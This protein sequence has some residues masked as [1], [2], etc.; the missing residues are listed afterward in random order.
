MKLILYNNLS[1]SNKVDKWNEYNQYCEDAKAYAKQLL[2][3][4]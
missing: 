4:V 1:E 3:L 2:N